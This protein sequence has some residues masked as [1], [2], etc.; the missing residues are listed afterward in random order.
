MFKGLVI[1]TGV[2]VLEL[3]DALIYLDDPPHVFVCD[4]EKIK[5]ELYFILKQEMF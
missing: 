1:N 3:F 2:D 5:C 4:P